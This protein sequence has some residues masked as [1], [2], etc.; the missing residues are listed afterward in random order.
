[1]NNK[2]A[3]LAGITLELASLLPQLHCSYSINMIILIS[4]NSIVR[5]DLESIRKS[6]LCSANFYPDLTSSS[7]HKILT[8]AISHRAAS[9]FTSIRTSTVNAEICE[10]SLRSSVKCSQPCQI[11]RMDGSTGQTS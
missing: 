6:Y 1:M 2:V 8:F 7:M 3:D 5:T 11:N 4:I 10:V 9:C